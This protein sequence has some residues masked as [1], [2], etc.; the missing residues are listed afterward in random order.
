MIKRFILISILIA[1]IVTP[2]YFCSSESEGPKDSGADIKTEDIKDTYFDACC[3]PLDA[4]VDIE[5]TYRDICCAVDVN[6]S[7]E[8]IDTYVDICCEPE[9]AEEDILDTYLDACC[10]IDE[11]IED[12]PNPDVEITDDGGSQ[13]KIKILTI[14]SELNEEGKGIFIRDKEIYFTG[15]VYDQGYSS[16]DLLIGY[17]N[18]KTLTKV[19]NI[20]E[21]DMGFGIEGDENQLYVGGYT[22]SSGVFKG[23]LATFDYTLNPVKQYTYNY[24][25]TGIEFFAFK[26]IGQDRYALAGFV[27]DTDNEAAVYIV[28]SKGEVLSS[29]IFVKNRDQEFYAIDVDKNGDI[30]LAGIDVIDTTRWTDI[31]VAKLNQNLD[32]IWE[33]RYGSNE[34]DGANDV[35]VLPS[36]DILVA[37]YTEK[38]QG[39]TG[40]DGYALLLDGEGN[41]KFEKVF[42]ASGDGEIR[43]ATVSSD[44]NLVFVTVEHIYDPFTSTG[45]VTLIKTDLSGNVIDGELLVSDAS[46]QRIEPYSNGHIIIGTDYNP[47]SGKGSSDLLLIFVKEF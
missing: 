21:F 39:T 15:V 24:Q 3:G 1:L 32:V 20:Q 31:Y 36:G 40:R 45:D 23:L 43:S 29:K 16:S 11:K 42:E 2:F 37:G 46:V 30:I 34:M 17:T 44:G 13:E 27:P 8:G 33:K 14:G 38:N 28:N 19:L 4:V 18:E 5:D 6:P 7:D 35:R 12:A 41:L 22:G 10:G 47:P 25:T 26:R 9:D